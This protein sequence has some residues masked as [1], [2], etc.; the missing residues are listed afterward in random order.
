[1]KASHKTNLVLVHGWGMNTAVWRS[2]ATSLNDEFELSLI[3]LPGHGNANEVAGGIEDWADYCLQQ[4]PERAIWCGWSL[5]GQIALHIAAHHAARL[6]AL[7]MLASTPR[8]VAEQNWHCA[9]PAH[10]FEAFVKA[11]TKD[12]ESTLV[13]FLSLQVRG[14]EGAAQVLKQL[15]KDMRQ[16][17]LPTQQALNDGLLLLNSLDLRAELSQL[18]CPVQWLLGERDSLI[19]AC[20]AEALQENHSQNHIDMIPTAGHAPFLSHPQRVAAALQ[21]FCRESHA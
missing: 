4:A 5:G 11:V 20:I 17:A 21:Q 10:T 6:S 18:S 19:P 7:F 2:L 3:Q 14:S 9:M 15:R 8:F 16:Q 12:I 13:R 1:M